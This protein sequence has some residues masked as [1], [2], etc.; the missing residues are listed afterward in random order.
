MASTQ[1]KTILFF[2]DQTDDWL[3]HINYIAKKA[4]YT[5]WL[6]SFME[7][8]CG[9][10]KS[11][12]RGMEPT[13]TENLGEY[14]SLYELAERYTHTTDEAGLVNAILIFTMRA[15]MLLQY[16]EPGVS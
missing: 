4:V 12:T 14:S 1:R 7:D 13:I 8:L 10:V 9:K 15:A 3:D 6:K 2:G 5:P 11:E 16:V